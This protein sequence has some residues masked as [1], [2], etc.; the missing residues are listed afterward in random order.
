MAVDRVSIRPAEGGFIVNLCDRSKDGH[1]G[2]DKDIVASSPE[3]VMK[4]LGKSIASS[5]KG[6]GGRVIDGAVPD[7][8]SE[9]KH[10]RSQ[11]KGRKKAARKR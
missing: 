10:G 8:S 1:M 9:S 5:K 3:Q 7:D 6:K 2:H 4:I 11:K